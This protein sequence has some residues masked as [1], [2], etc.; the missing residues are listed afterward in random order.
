METAGPDDSYAHPHH[1]CERRSCFV[2]P[3]DAEGDTP[4]RVA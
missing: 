3:P 4:E 2:P 1:C